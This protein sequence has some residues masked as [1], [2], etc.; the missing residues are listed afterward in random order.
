MFLVALLYALIAGTFT[1]GKLVLQYFNPIFFIGLRMILGGSLLLGYLYFFKRSNLFIKKKNIFDF[2]SIILFHIF[3]AFVAEFWALKYL[4]SSKVCLFY[5]LSPFI[6]AIFSYVWFSERMTIKKFFGL[7]L[8]FCAFLPVLIDRTTD[9][10][11][12]AVGFFSWPELAMLFSVVSATYGWIVVKKLGKQGY[13]MITVNGIG[14][15]F[16][17]I[18]SIGVSFFIEGIPS[19]RAI[20][21]DVSTDIAISMGYTFLL[22]FLA[23]VVFYNLYGFLL[24][25]YTATFLSFAGFLTPIIAAFY[26]WIFLG[27]TI[28]SSFFLTIAFVFVGLYIF[29]QEELRQGYITAKN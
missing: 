23:N 13:S 22:I 8:G 14:M 19:F 5:N 26:G 7:A 29:Y 24:R 4:S 25:K 27:E 17:G 28:R 15:F 6:A 20:S 16:G 11:C 3:F 9:S 21:G 2:A 10:S 18:L 1:I 12:N